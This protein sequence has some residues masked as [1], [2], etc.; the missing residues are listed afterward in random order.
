MINLLFQISFVHYSKLSTVMKSTRQSWGPEDN[1]RK[2]K[3]DASDVTMLGGDYVKNSTSATTN[4]NKY[5]I[6]PLVEFK[7]FLGDYYS[8]ALHSLVDKTNSCRYS[9]S[10]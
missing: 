8:L 5:L 10:G 1:M 9:Q 4:I 2:I 3:I 6:K 7:Q